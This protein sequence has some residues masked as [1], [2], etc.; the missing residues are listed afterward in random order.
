MERI[1]IAIL[2]QMQLPCKLRMKGAERPTRRH[3]DALIRRSGCR[4]ARHLSRLDAGDEPSPLL[5]TQLTRDR[6]GLG[7]ELE[8][9][10]IFGQRPAVSQPKMRA[11]DGPK[12][13]AAQM[14]LDAVLHR[15][16]GQPAELPEVRRPVL[17][18]VVAHACIA[19]KLLPRNHSVG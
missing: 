4:R 11:A 13:A 10:P 5:R 12:P 17:E 6:R 2:R 19:V 16:T 3:P 7:R 15:V 9:D 18:M 14:A 8:R 1:K